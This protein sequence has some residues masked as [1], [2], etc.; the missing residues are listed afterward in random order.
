MDLEH[1]LVND[2][3]RGRRSVIRLGCW[4]AGSGRRMRTPAW[5]CGTAQ[6]DADAGLVSAAPHKQDADAG[7]G[8]A[9]QDADAGLVSAEPHRQDADVGLVLRR[10]T[11]KMRTPAAAPHKQDADA[12]LVLRNR[13]SRLRP[14]SRSA[15][16]TIPHGEF[17]VSLP[18]GRE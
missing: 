9:K 15:C 4:V 14:G 8:T 3:V 18:A 11:S 1:L 12:G 10:R 6:Q 2:P 7:C 13:T 17:S 5:F 16:G